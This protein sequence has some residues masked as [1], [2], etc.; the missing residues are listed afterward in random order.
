MTAAAF[1]GFAA[2]APKLLGGALCLDFVNTVNWRGRPT[3]PEDRLTGYD[4]LV[5]WA[6]RAGALGRREREALLREG[7]RRPEAA[8]RALARA[9]ELREAGARLLARGGPTQQ[10]DL[11]LVNRLL[12]R[13]PQ[14]GALER[15]GEEF[16]WASEA[17]PLEL[18]A[19]LWPIVWSFAD[20]LASDR[21]ERVRTCGDPECGWMFVDESRAGSRRWCSMEGCGNRNKARRHY[22]RARP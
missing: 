14:R 11:A 18:E 21:R 15:A 1:P 12:A 13:A 5:F 6:W 4:E 9:V 19:P 20:L 2:A 10:A 22:A 17:R 3:A 16:R 7:R 8:G